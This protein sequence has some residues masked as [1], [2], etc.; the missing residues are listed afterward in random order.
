MTCP[1]FKVCGKSM[2]SGLKVCTSCF[3]RFK[4]EVL[5]FKICECSNCNKSDDCVKFRKC[6]HF[7]CVK[8]YDKIDK[9]P[10][11]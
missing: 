10:D 6:E 8:C 7:V 3:W 4:N 2:R 11:C 1:N 5:E 9:C